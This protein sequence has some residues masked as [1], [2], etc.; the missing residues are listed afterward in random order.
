MSSFKVL[1][2][3]SLKKLSPLTVEKDSFDLVLKLS[4]DSDSFRVTF[5][6]LEKPFKY[7]TKI[8][9]SF[10]EP[11]MFKW[12][13]L[14]LRFFLASIA[15]WLMN[16]I[17]FTYIQQN[18]VHLINLLTPLVISWSNTRNCAWRL[19]FVTLF[20]KSTIDC[21][22]TCGVFSDG[23]SFVPTWNTWIIFTNWWLHVILH[24]TNFWARKQSQV[25]LLFVVKFFCYF[26]TLNMFYNTAF[27]R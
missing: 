23:I 3:D 17:I 24:V 5:T 16:G 14:W 10:L 18:F 9:C 26:P 25:N 8:S 27:P 20:A 1:S 12:N 6:Q 13:L 2:W 7:L 4:K 22:I 15:L 21:A 11:L 19:S